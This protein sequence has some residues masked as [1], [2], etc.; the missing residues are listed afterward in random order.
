[1]TPQLSVNECLLK[2]KTLGIVDVIPN[3]KWAPTQTFA[4]KLVDLAGQKGPVTKETWRDDV[5]T[6]MCELLVGLPLSANEIE[7]C[8]E[9]L[10][11]LVSH[12]NPFTPHIEPVERR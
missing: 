12:G 11:V 2:L 4:R 10:W 6:A 9:V 7:Q 5:Y 8:G 3:G 1:M